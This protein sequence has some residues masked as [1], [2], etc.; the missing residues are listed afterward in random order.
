VGEH[1]PVVRVAA[2]DSLGFLGAA[3]DAAANDAASADTEIG[4]AASDTRVVVV[5]ARED[6][7]ISR[8]V[9]AVLQG[10]S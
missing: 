3:L 9:R 1:A 8:Q 6:L 7:E 10:A 4:A 2:I 5:T